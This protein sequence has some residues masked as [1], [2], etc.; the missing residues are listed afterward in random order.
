MVTYA[1]LDCYADQIYV[2][3]NDEMNKSQELIP[4]ATQAKYGL[5]TIYF[6][7]VIVF[8]GFIRNAY[9][10][11][12]DRNKPISFVNILLSYS[13]YLGYKSIKTPN[14]LPSSLAYLGLYTI[15]SFYLL[16]YLF[17]PHF[18]YRECLGFGSPPLGVRAGVMAAALTPFIYI[19]SGKSNVITLLS[20]IGYE[21]LN[22]IHQFIG[23]AS[24]F[25]GIAHVIPFVY[26][27]LR[28]GGSQYLSE[29][30]ATF[31]YYSGI[32]PLA[33]LILLCML[34][35]SFFRKF[36]Y[37]GFL[38]L[39]WIMGIAYFATLWWHIDNLLD[40]QHYMYAALAF[41][42]TQLIFRVLIKTCFKPGQMFL[43]SRKAE[44]IK[45]NDTTFTIN[46]LNKTN[47]AWAPGQHVF[48]RFKD[49]SILDN[50]PF[51]IASMDSLKFI[52]VKKNGLTSKILK[53][54]DDYLVHEKDIFIDGPYGGVPR[55]PLNF[56][57]IILLATGSGI[58]AIL[59]FVSFVAQNFEKSVV[60]SITLTW[61]IRSLAD[62]NWFEQE[63]ISAK[64]ILGEYLDLNVFVC[65]NNDLPANEKDIGRSDEEKIVNPRLLS[66]IY[67]SYHKPSFKRLIPEFK[68]T[69]LKKNMF[70]SS[71]SA[72]MR[73]DVAN[74]VSNLQPLVFNNDYHRTGIEE[75]YLHTEAFNW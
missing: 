53:K 25:L 19:L 42:A 35:N 5:Y 67:I 7:V 55:D 10:Q 2:Q 36:F 71:G 16:M 56:D 38:H 64:E 63:L 14:F 44:L 46:I 48:L 4:W 47:L 1:G 11:W 26:H 40:I 54:L 20:G 60:R 24:L 27:S 49:K 28:D 73:H 66:M 23:V 58:S 68:L 8:L 41:W 18:Y 62:L 43:K 61:T 45:V 37:E 34:G 22:S 32:P 59:P 74:G 13:R 72:S 69:L 50:H 6:M 70:I 29:N 12:T 33:L 21:K 31:N 52:I 3:Y 51:S 30:F 39:H 17:V 57:R 65:S 75:I 15:F 9:Y